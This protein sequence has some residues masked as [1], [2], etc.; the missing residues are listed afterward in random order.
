LRATGPHE[1]DNGRQNRND[2]R[3][4]ATL[5]HDTSLEKGW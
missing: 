5:A 4:S 1:K 3:E 2:D